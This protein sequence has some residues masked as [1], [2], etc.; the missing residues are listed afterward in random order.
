[1]EILVKPILTEKA[2]GLSEKRNSFTFRVNVEANKIQIK[3]A[4]EKAYGVSVL[5]VNTLVVDGKSKSKYTKTGFVSGRSVKYKKAVVT[6]R[7][8]ETIDY[9][10]NI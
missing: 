3:Q 10:A 9:Y 6:L 4:V 1:M 2:S 7:A 8:G 5:S